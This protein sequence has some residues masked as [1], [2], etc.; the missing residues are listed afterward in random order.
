M[1]TPNAVVSNSDVLQRDVEPFA[2]DD[3]NPLDK[4][5][6]F[7]VINES[8]LF[9]RIISEFFEKLV[10]EEGGEEKEREGM[11]PRSRTPPFLGVM[12]M[13]YKRGFRVWLLREYQMGVVQEGLQALKG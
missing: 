10:G 11:Y 12:H 8:F 9:K 7:G 1:L 13:E 5:R 6:I 2:S 4:T 3:R